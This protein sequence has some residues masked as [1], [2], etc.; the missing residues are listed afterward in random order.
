MPDRGT[1]PRPKREVYRSLGNRLPEIGSTMAS[2]Q[3]T[4]GNIGAVNDGRSIGIYGLSKYGRCKY[5]LKRGIYGVDK[6][7]SAAY[8]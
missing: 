7:G 3:S 6:Y 1:S 8:W 5:G 4:S 2:T